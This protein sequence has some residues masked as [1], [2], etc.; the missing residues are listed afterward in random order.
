MRA[1]FFAMVTLGSPAAQGAGIT[2][3]QGIGVNTPAAAAVAAATAGF[4]RLV[5]MAKGRIFKKGILSIMVAAG[6]LEALTQLV[7]R[8]IRLDGAIPKEHIQ[9]APFT[10]CC[11]PIVITPSHFDHN[12]LQVP[13]KHLCHNYSPVGL[14]HPHKIEHNDLGEDLFR[15]AVL[16]LERH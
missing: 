3:V 4:A 14:C 7:G 13:S 11:P 10:T 1:G 9:G 6:I 2:G 5:H 8:T 12:F 15:K 16:S